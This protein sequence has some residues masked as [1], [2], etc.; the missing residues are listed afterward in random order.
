MLSELADHLF[1][2]N[3]QR[4]EVKGKNMTQ[5]H[6]KQEARKWLLGHNAAKPG[7]RYENGLSVNGQ[8]DPSLL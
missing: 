4:F 7:T 2:L 8:P 5:D 3:A 1:S 6:L